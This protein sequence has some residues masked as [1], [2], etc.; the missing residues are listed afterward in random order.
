MSGK[1]ARPARPARSARSARQAKSTTQDVAAMSMAFVWESG[2]GTIVAW[3]VFALCWAEQHSRRYL[4]RGCVCGSFSSAIWKGMM[5]CCTC[6]ATTER[7]TAVRT[8]SLVPWVACS[9]HASRYVHQSGRALVRSTDYSC[10]EYALCPAPNYLQGG[11]VCKSKCKGLWRGAGATARQWSGLGSCLRLGRVYL[12][13]LY[14][15]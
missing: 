15:V 6:S 11:E 9:K 13:L 7:S 4:R 8:S 2:L 3:I 14:F 5:D 12:V 10:T 1:Q